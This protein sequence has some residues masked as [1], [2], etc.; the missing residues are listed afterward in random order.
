MMIRSIL[1]LALLVQAAPAAVAVRI[2]LGVGDQE[3]ANWSGGVTARGASITGMEPWRFDGD[4]AMQ[5]GNRW[6]MSTHQI[7]V[8][9][10]AAVPI[11]RPLSGNGVVVQLTGETEDSS[12]EVQTPRGAFSVRL[13]EIPYGAS[14]TGLNGKAVAERVPP[15]VRITSDAQEQDQPAAAA[16]AAGNV[17]LA[18]LE[19]KHHPDQ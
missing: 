19:F 5:P 7:R 14:K 15:F 9:G 3:A 17:W 11:P 6:K 4:D 8:F 16:D 2:L 1:T 10:G 18:Y 13:S 12:L